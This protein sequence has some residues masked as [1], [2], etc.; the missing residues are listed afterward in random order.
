MYMETLPFAANVKTRASRN[1][2]RN[3]ILGCLRVTRSGVRAGRRPTMIWVMEWNFQTKS[4]HTH[5]TLKIHTKGS[6]LRTQNT[7][8]E[9]KKAHTKTS[10]RARAQNTY[11]TNAPASTTARTAGWLTCRSVRRGADSRTSRSDV[12]RVQCDHRYGMTGRSTKINARPC[13][14]T[15]HT[16]LATRLSAA[17][18]VFYTKLSGK[19]K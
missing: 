8:I 17:P 1:A 9:K 7:T 3:P 16:W 4:C 2:P 5:K 14:W 6:S 12:R 11:R 15:R 10:T 19:N 18:L 13:T